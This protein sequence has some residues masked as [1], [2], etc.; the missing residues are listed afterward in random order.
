MEIFYEK[1]SK[2]KASLW[3]A[4][5][6]FFLVASCVHILFQS[7][8]INV[9]VNMSG[10]FAITLLYDSTFWKK[11][12]T[13]VMLYSMKMLCDVLVMVTFA[14]YDIGYGVN[15][16]LGI[17][18]SLLIFLIVF[19]LEKFYREKEDLPIPVLTWILLI[20]FPVFSSLVVINEFSN[21]VSRNSTILAM[22]GIL[23]LNLLFYFLFN[24]VFK[25][26]RVESRKAFV[27]RQMAAYSNQLSL[28]EIA[29]SESDSLRH[30]MR[31]QI[32]MIKFHL[33]KEEFGQ[34]LERVKEIEELYLANSRIMT[35]TGN[36]EID[37][38]INYLIGVANETVH[39]VTYNICLP[40]RLQID[41]VPLNIIIG[42]LLENAI[43]AAQSVQEGF[44]NI[45]I[46]YKQGV[47]FFDVY[48]S[49]CNSLKEINGKLFSTKKNPE[50]H[51]LGLN[52]VKRVVENLN[53][54]IKIDHDKST[55]RAQVLLYS[56]I[57]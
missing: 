38:I 19:L 46:N 8:I 4:F 16:I 54:T 25:F 26:Y 44:L 30:D 45:N 18:T 43:Q 21:S 12:A 49:H 53:G 24:T 40:D 33:E 5:I 7:I 50:N 29:K 37:S 35:D 32:N 27:E 39:H 51:G 31:Y 17:I 6:L 41:I 47:L 11:I 23:I 3:I 28:I 22:S 52:N 36:H 55:F 9:F 48:N 57:L 14:Y 15:E 1:Q 20:C 10:I 42:N 13:T 34:A 56:E 2:N